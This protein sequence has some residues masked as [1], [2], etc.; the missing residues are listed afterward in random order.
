[1]RKTALQK[2]RARLV[3]TSKFTSTR[4]GAYFFLLI[5]TLCWGA[6]LVV[7]KPALEIASPFRFL[8]YRYLLASGMVLP[9]LL[10]NWQKIRPKMRDLVNIAWIE[11][12]GTGLALAILYTGLR[13]TTAIEASLIS[14]TT[15]I[16]IV[17]GGLLFLRERLEKHE[18]VGLGVAFLGT[19]A[20]TL[21]PAWLLSN[22]TLGESISLVGNLLIFGQNI[23]T[24]IYFLLS[25]RY[26]AQ[27][28]KFFAASISFVIGLACFFGLS[29]VESGGLSNLMNA[30]LTD[31]SHSS[32]LTA[33]IYMSVFGSIIGYT[34]Y[35][36]GQN[37]VEASEASIFWYLQPLVYL[38][39]GVVLLGERVSVVQVLTLGLVL[40][41]VVMAS[42]RFKRKRAKKN[43]AI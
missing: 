25:K 24:A 29:L 43:Q 12:I 41:G 4:L 39:L 23:V 10:L 19:I 3:T 16:F 21:L 13:Y 34:S 31:I 8:L 7:T 32:V 22:S 40:L 6:A 17:F 9:Y 15:P 30:I 26:Y 37:H 5:N 33:A 11:L 27:L 18:A 35:I 1:M 2:D 20:M 42:L 14:T 36:K 28:P 38:P